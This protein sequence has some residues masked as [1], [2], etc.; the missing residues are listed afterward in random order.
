MYGCY[1]ARGPANLRVAQHWATRSFTN[2]TCSRPACVRAC[3]Q[4]MPAA[5]THIVSMA[6]QQQPPQ[7][8]LQCSAVQC[9][10]AKRTRARCR[11]LLPTR[12]VEW[13]AVELP[14]QFMENW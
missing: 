6:H 13:D 3:M 2:H 14:S 9:T 5:R 4:S 10:N 1:A 11:V 7:A 8:T 12:G